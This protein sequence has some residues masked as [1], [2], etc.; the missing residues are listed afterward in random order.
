[1]I[2]GQ[3]PGYDK[4]SKAKKK[5]KTTN[6]SKI[7]WNYEDQSAKFGRLTERR[8]YFLERQNVWTDFSKMGQLFRNSL[9]HAGTMA[10]KSQRNSLSRI[11]D[12]SSKKKRSE[13]CGKMRSFLDRQKKEKGAQM[14]RSPRITTKA[15]R[16]Q[17]K[18]F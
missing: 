10:K 15:E 12:K 3:G 4:R 2:P 7:I 13:T 18:R 16:T 8:S 1:M 14:D 9:M 5:K 17:K 6:G 11:G